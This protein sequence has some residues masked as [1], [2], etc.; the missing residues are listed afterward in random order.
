MDPF[1]ARVLMMGVFNLVAF[2]IHHAIM[3]LSN[4]TEDV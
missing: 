1:L 4:L 2:L 3:S